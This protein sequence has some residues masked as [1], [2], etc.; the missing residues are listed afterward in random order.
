MSEVT[1]VLGGSRSGKSRFAESLATKVPG[2]KHYI[3]TAEAV[4]AEMQARIAAHLEQRGVDWLTH[5][6]PLDVVAELETCA[7]DF[8][9]IDCVTVWIGNLMYHGRDW[10]AAVAEFGAALK[11]S[12][13]RVVIVSNEVG[14]GVVPETALGRAFRDAQGRT[15][16]LLAALADEVVLVAAGLPMWLKKPKRKGRRGSAGDRGR[17][18]RG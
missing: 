8:V 15:N 7:G 18:R 12:R 16:Q 4:D 9:L 13:A 2:P 11:R 5:E 17:G 10:E 14:M 1:L 6:V 3:A